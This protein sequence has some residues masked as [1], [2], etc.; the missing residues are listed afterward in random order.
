[1][2]DMPDFKTAFY[3]PWCFPVKSGIVWVQ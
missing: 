3:G 1:M 2:G